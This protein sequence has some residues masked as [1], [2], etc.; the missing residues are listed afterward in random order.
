MV[1]LQPDSTGSSTGPRVSLRNGGCVSCP[2]KAW[3]Q[4]ASLNGTSHSKLTASVSKTNC[5]DAFDLIWY[6]KIILCI[7][8]IQR[9]G[10]RYNCVKNA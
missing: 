3:G 2:I 1:L 8:K 4:P 9:L 5:D 10:P 7:K 6:D